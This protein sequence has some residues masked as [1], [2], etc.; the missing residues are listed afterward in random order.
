MFEVMGFLACLAILIYGSFVWVVWA[1]NSLGR[2]NIGG[3]PNEPTEKALCLFAA[4]VLGTFWYKLLSCL[5][6]TM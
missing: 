5:S 1:F 6:I 3:V 2:Y 4:A